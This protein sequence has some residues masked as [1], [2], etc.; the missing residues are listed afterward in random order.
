[1]STPESV[2]PL[3]AV[4][5]RDVGA[6]DVDAEFAADERGIHLDRRADERGRGRRNRQLVSVDDRQ[7]QFA[8]IL[9]GREVDALGGAVEVEDGKGAERETAGT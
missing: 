7:Q 5:Q 4:G 3:A 1:M 6:G 9:V 8:G 2:T